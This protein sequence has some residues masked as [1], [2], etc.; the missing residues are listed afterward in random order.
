MPPSTST[1]LP[2]IYY[3]NSAFQILHAFHGRPG[4][5]NDG[6]DY[7]YTASPSPPKKK[8]LCMLLLLDQRL[9]AHLIMGMLITQLLPLLLLYQT[10]LGNL[11][12]GM[13]I[14]MLGLHLLLQHPLTHQ[15]MIT[16]LVFFMYASLVLLVMA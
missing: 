12:M 10:M 16:K 9:H 6:N 14:I 7:N 3:S 13:S 2:T 8:M 11:I 5:S 1:V 15:M 4:Y